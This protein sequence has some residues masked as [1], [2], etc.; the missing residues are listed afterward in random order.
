ML[1]EL[2]DLNYVFQEGKGSRKKVLSLRQF[3][4]FFLC[5]DKLT[6]TEQF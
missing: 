2:I 5:A 6:T 4:N 3:W 1:E